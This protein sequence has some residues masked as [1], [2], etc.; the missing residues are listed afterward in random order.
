[1]AIATYEMHDKRKIQNIIYE[2]LENK[3]ITT[4]DSMFIRQNFKEKRK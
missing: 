3:K 2:K 1:M 4:E